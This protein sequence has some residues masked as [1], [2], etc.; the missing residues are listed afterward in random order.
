MLFPI[1][2]KSNG[3]SAEPTIVLKPQD[4][5]TYFDNKD[6]NGN[7]D[8][9]TEKKSKCSLDLLDLEKAQNCRF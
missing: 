2:A 9:S 7:V 1:L 6:S 3:I 4:R 8:S 5:A